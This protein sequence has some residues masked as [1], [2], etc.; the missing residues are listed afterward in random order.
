M[1]S[2]QLDI[3]VNNI[4][5][6]FS[7][8]QNYPNPFNPDTRIQYSLPIDTYV[9][10]NI[11]DL[12]GKI[13]KSLVKSFQRAGFKNITWDGNNDFGQTLSAGMYILVFTSDEYY[14]SKK[15]LLLK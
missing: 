9:S 6:D 3:E 10:I 5:N 2:G 12:N 15:M 11:V 14:A 7:L 8:K 1:Y 13:V 4:P